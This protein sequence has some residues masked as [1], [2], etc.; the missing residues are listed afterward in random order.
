MDSDSV[1]SFVC[2]TVAVLV[3]VVGFIGLLALYVWRAQA[4]LRA[5]AAEGGFRIIRF[6]KTNI[7]GRGPFNW[8]TNG[9]HQIIYHIRVRDSEGRERSGWVRCGSY[10]G[11]IL[12][13]NKAEVKWEE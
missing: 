8:W 13:S 5:W 4:V 1:K 10:L 12:F 3:V 6:Q 2:A 11:G 9:R 7:T